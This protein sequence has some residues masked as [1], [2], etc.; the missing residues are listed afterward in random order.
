MWIRPAL[1]AFMLLAASTAVGQTYP[2]LPCNG[3]CAADG[4]ATAS[5]AAASYPP[6]QACGDA[7]GGGCQMS[8]TGHLAGGVRARAASGWAG[9]TGLGQAVRHNVMASPAA[10]AYAHA[11]M[12]W[13][14]GHKPLGGNGYH[15]SA[16]AYPHMMGGSQPA[17]PG[18]VV[19]GMDGGYQDYGGTC[20]GPH[21]FDFLMEGVLLTRTGDDD[22][23]L[24][25]Q[26]I[27]GR[28]PTECRA[29]I[30]RYRFRSGRCLSPGRSLAAERGLLPAKASI[31]ADWNGMTPPSY[32]PTTTTCIPPSVTS[33]T[34]RLEA[35]RTPT[36]RR[37]PA[38]FTI[39][40]WTAWR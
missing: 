32:R 16:A 18:G 19:P 37:G 3:G 30:E 24:M 17:F 29:G 1:T 40:T 35:L 6:C 31:W 39:P 11:R 22:V 25:S 28:R 38:C 34:S 4:Y 12:G 8:P 27:R 26:G 2:G 10:A 21:W 15:P 14:P 33:A 9:M 20:C 36:R 5:Y 13:L 7:C 23:A